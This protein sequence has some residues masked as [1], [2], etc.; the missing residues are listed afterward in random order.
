[1]PGLVFLQAQEEAG[2]AGSRKRH[3]KG[4]NSNTRVYTTP[5]QHNGVED[6]FPAGGDETTTDTS[7]AAPART[8]MSRRR[9]ILLGVLGTFLVLVLAHFIIIVHF[10]LSLIYLRIVSIVVPMTFGFLYHERPK[11]HLLIAFGVGVG[12]AVVSILTCPRSWRS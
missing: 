5:V 4:S 9:K 11:R 6:D 1:M 2:L 8:G 10:D 12:I 3:R 7:A